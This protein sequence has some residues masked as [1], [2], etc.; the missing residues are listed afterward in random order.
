MI[1]QTVF[2]KSDTRVKLTVNLTKQFWATFY[3]IFQSYTE[4]RATIKSLYVLNPE[5]IKQ[6]TLM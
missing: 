4:N 5:K 2:I 1:I 3:K 6:L